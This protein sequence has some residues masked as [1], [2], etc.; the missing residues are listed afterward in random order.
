MTPAHTWFE[1]YQPWRRQ[2]EIGF[3]VLVLTVQK[4]YFQCAKALIRSGLWDPARQVDRSTLTPF[5]EVLKD[6][7]RLETPLPDDATIRAELA[8]D[9]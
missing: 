5:G 4:A 8:A 6:H 3:W 9:L 7:C 1:R 2:A